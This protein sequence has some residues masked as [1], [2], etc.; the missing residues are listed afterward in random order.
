MTSKDFSYR[1]RIC[2]E[3]YNDDDLKKYGENCTPFK[4]VPV[5]DLNF[6]A[7]IAPHYHETDT[8]RGVMS[9]VTIEVQDV[10]Y[11]G[12]KI[13]DKD[14]EFLLRDIPGQ[15]LRGFVK[16]MVWDSLEDAIAKC[17]ATEVDDVNMEAD[18]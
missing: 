14:T 16:G 6:D 5:L 8:D 12:E 11:V 3:L 18:G 1:C 17:E 13:I 4:N 15:R 9:E 7:E 10:R 2:V